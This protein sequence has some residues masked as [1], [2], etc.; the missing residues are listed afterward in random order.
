MKACFYYNNTMKK[1]IKLMQT[2]S[3][4]K[5]YLK[6][7]EEIFSPTNVSDETIFT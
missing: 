4:A 2:I 6:D 5:T 1:L 7:E 3:F